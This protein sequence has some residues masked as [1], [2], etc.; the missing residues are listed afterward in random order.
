[1]NI[2]VRIDALTCSLDECYLKLQD[3][4]DILELKRDKQAL[5]CK[6]SIPAPLLSPVMDS[7]FRADGGGQRVELPSLSHIAPQWK[8][9]LPDFMNH[10][11]KCDCDL[12]TS[13][14]YSRLLCE[15][16]ALFGVYYRLAGRGTDAVEFFE[17]K[18]CT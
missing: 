12:C 8:F 4:C 3:I 7:D 10:E 1:M 5:L 17:G 9:Q 13:F 2:S 18:F 11:Q 15:V 16:T 6:P 14:V